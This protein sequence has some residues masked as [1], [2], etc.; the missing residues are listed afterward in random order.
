MTI[1]LQRRRISIAIVL[2]GAGGLGAIGPAQ[3]SEQVIRV[4]ARK[5]DFTPNTIQ[6]KKGV[7]VVLE[8]TTADVPMGFNAPDFKVRADILPG[9]IARLRIVPDK[10]G[11]FDFVC[12]VFCGSGH[13]D[14]TGTIVVS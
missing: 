10:A 14:M 11:T 7:P 12:D 8:L 13:E 3:T 1:D 9:K 2:I 5:F 4:V 6:L